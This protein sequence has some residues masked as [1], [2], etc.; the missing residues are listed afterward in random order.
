MT[1]RYAFMTSGPEHEAG[2]AIAAVLRGITVTEAANLDIN[3]G[4]VYVDESD[5]SNALGVVALAGLTAVELVI[6]S[7]DPDTED[8]ASDD[9]DI[10][11][12]RM[13][14]T[15]VVGADGDIDGLL[16]EWREEVFN[17]LRPRQKLIRDLA[18]E[19]RRV[20]VMPGEDVHR[21]IFEAE[22]QH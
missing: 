17:L 7:V 10:P 5:D 1:D 21:F 3:N 8:Q 19:L 4:Y 18:A 11:R 9:C 2:H 6:G 16:A 20:R 12:A 13:Y 14:A 22:T 15:A